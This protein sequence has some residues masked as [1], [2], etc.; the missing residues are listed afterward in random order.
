MNAQG[1][2]RL[3][4]AARAR[5]LPWKLS[6]SAKDTSQDGFKPKGAVLKLSICRRPIMQAPTLVPFLL[7]LWV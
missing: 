4:A 6:V 5:V 1:A 7:Q 3:P 2:Q